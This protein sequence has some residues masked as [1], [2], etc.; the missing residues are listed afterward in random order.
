MGPRVKAYSLRDNADRR[1]EE[2]NLVLEGK[3]GRTSANNLLK[4][5]R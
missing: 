2:S 4:A 3:A 5:E 1:W